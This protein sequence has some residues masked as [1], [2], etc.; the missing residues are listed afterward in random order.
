MAIPGILSSFR[1]RDFTNTHVAALISNTSSIFNEVLGDRWPSNQ[2]VLL[3]DVG[4]Y[5][6]QLS[7]SD[8]TGCFLKFRLHPSDAHREDSLTRAREIAKRWL[9]LFPKGSQVL[10]NGQERIK[11]GETVTV[12]VVTGTH[13]IGD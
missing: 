11:E 8:E 5:L 6:R 12:V 3:E 13:S 1:P 10:W 2:S 4:S 7:H 9:A